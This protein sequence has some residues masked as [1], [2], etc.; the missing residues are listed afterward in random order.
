M[1]NAQ[2]INKLIICQLIVRLLVIVQNNKRCV[3]LVLKYL[4]NILT[5]LAPFEMKVLKM[6][7]LISVSF[8]P[9]KT[10]Q[11]LTVLIN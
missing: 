4:N 7:P 11:L 3:V 8:G 9:D 10:T 6:Q 2:L 1:Y 5:I